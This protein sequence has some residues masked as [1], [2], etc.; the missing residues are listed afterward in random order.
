MAKRKAP[1][2]ASSKKDA[3]DLDHLL[4]SDKSKLIDIDLHGTLADF[5]SDP[6]NWSQISAE[7]KDFI[8]NLLPPYVELTD[9]G[10]IPN[11]FWKYNPEFRLD[12]RNLQEDLRAGRMD[13]E[14]QSQAHQAMEERAT[15]AF[16]NFK[17]REFEQ[18]WGQKQKVDWKYLAG[19]ASKIKL[20]ELLDAGLFK[21]GDIWSFDHTFGRG[22][23]AVEIQ[24]ECKILKIDGKSVTFAIPPG[25][26]K[27]ARRFDHPPTE[28]GYDQAMTSPQSAISEVTTNTVLDHV[29]MQESLSTT[30]SPL[31]VLEP[32]SLVNRSKVSDHGED[33]SGG[34]AETQAEES[35]PDVVAGDETQTSST[36]ATTKTDVEPLIPTAHST[37]KRMPMES[38]TQ[39]SSPLS[40]IPDM[41]PATRDPGV[42]YFT[43]STLW[44]LEKKIIEIDGRLP[45]TMR[46]ASAWRDIRCRRNEQDMG[47]LFE[48]RDEYYAY[49]VTGRDQSPRKGKRS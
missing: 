22:D 14:W 5:F 32:M 41:T 44:P 12:C 35:K 38:S 1:S 37:P 17:E 10:S 34:T 33:L 24:K 9:D 40:D 42:I 7:D 4:T 45:S 2:R 27:F 23:E 36:I 13:P 19:D 28:S 16:D 26:L 20:E 6:D 31:N 47:S 39:S 48:M 25:Q 15:G 29:M 3:Y 43:T 11:D 46:T 18:Y 21:E 30:E 8:R 49:Q